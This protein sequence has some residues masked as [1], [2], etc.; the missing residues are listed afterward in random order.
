[1]AQLFAHGGQLRI[2]GDHTEVVQ[3][4]VDARTPVSLNQ[5]DDGTCV[6]AYARERQYSAS[7][8]ID[9]FGSQPQTAV[10]ELERAFDVLDVQHDVI[11]TRNV[12]ED[13]L[14]F[15]V[16]SRNQRQATAVL[17]AAVRS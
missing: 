10:I 8:L 13:P 7:P 3:I 9:A 14:R 2:V 6:E 12:H 15:S 17:Y 5:V 16:R 1:G 11:Q 4:R